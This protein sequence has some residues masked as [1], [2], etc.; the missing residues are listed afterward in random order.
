[1]WVGRDLQNRGLTHVGLF[2]ESFLFAKILRVKSFLDQVNQRLR[3][4]GGNQTEC[5]NLGVLR[6]R[7]WCIKGFRIN[8]STF[9]CSSKF[10]IDNITHMPVF[11][12]KRG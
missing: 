12:S 6:D 1:M 7:K 9:F 2:R 4:T 8:K 5:F 3:L 11:C 10:V